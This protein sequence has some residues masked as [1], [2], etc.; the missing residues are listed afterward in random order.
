MIHEDYL[1]RLLSTFFEALAKMQAMRKE[2]F[3]EKI[4]K[5]YST[6][7]NKE[8]KF[9]LESNAHELVNY[10]DNN[11]NGVLIKTE[12]LAELLLQEANNCKTRET[13]TEFYAKSL[14]LFEKIENESDTFSFERKEKIANIKLELEK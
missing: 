1:M 4:E 14:H 8:R 3:D 12:I 11:K 7:L 2:N 10:L 9:F 13:R 5:L 6:F